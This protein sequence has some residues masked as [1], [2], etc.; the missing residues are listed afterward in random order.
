MIMYYNYYLCLKR[1]KFRIKKNISK[2][3]FMDKYIY[4]RELAE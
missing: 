2:I 4:I 3:K 1:S